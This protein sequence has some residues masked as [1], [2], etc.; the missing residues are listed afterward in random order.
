MPASPRSST[1][2]SSSGDDPAACLARWPTPLVAAQLVWPAV[3]GDQLESQAP[4][5][6]GWGVGGALLMTWPD[7]ATPEQLLAFKDAAKVPLLIATDEEGGD[8]QRFRRLGALPAQ[9]QVAATMPVEDARRMVADHAAAMHRVGVD[10]VFGPVAD[11]GPADGSDGPMGDRVFSTDPQVVA[12]Y[13]TAYVRGWQR[14]GILP[15]LKHFPGHGSASADTHVAVARTPPLEELARRDLVP[16]RRLAG[17]DV[18]VMV[19]H[20]DVPGLTEDGGGPASL[21][22]AAITVL[23]RDQLGFAGHLVVTDALDM[24]AVAARA[25][26]PAAA[27]QA[28]AAGADVVVYADTAA[29]PQVIARLVDAESAGRLPPGRLHQAA[30]QVLATKGV[31][32]CDVT[33]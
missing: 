33:A 31:D 9:G 1:V 30:R 10:V 2:V 11:V 12:D 22:P 6:A 8:V 5:F 16:Y 15:V 20:L 13:A 27:E 21:S 14:G 24:Q 7:A 32:P 4:T 25:M 26:L 17:E 28:V 23:L 3:Y 18:G 19:G 29:T